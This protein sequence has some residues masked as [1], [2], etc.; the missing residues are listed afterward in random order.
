MYRFIHVSM[1]YGLL[2][3]GV[4]DQKNFIVDTF[5]IPKSWLD[6]ENCNP[7]D[8][9]PQIGDAFTLTKGHGMQI[10][11]MDTMEDCRWTRLLSTSMEPSLWQNGETLTTGQ[12]MRK[13]L[14]QYEP[15]TDMG[16]TMHEV[17]GHGPILPDSVGYS[18][19]ELT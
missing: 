16:V 11:E 3:F 1:R 14:R 12:R 15:E 18:K 9:L 2:T 8:L 19:K 5:S 10:Q 4:V 17:I 13:L 7:Q 6:Y